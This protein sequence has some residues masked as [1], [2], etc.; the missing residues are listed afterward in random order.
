MT[1]TPAPYT[2][3]VGVSVT[4]K[5]PAALRWAAAQAAQNRGHL[6]AVRAWRMPPSSGTTSGVMAARPPDEATV[7]KSAKRSLEADVTEILG[8]DHGAE[9]RLVRGSHRRVL[10]DESRDADLL[11][12]DAPRRLTG[13][14]LFA[15]RVVGAA[16][17]PVVVMPPSISEQPPGA[18]ERAGRAVGRAAVRSAGTAGRP[19]Y[20][21]P[22][23]PGRRGR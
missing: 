4:S 10:L 14:P 7:I 19:G 5:S 11:V 1:K 2:V 6:V 9:L 22:V 12:M 8:P 16:T 20:R 18:V 13:Q 23:P 21:P 3:V 15:Q 17:C